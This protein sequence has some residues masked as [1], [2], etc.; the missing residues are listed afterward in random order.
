MLKITDTVKV[1]S[2]TNCGGI[3]KELIPVGTICIIV[4]EHKDKDGS[5]Y[6]GVTPLHNRNDLF[7]YL[8]SELE[9][10]SLQ[11]VKKKRISVWIRR[12]RTC[13]MGNCKT[14][15]LPETFG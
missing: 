3:M 8:E 7:Y 12:K 6:Y 4:S 11:W 13:R 14:Y 9:K 10:G 15:C 1:I 2:K 5:I